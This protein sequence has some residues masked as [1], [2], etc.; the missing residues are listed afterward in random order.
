MLFLILVTLITSQILHFQAEE[1]SIIHIFPYVS[2]P[3]SFDMR[4]VT[5]FQLPLFFL[6]VW[7][8]GVMLKAQLLCT[9]EGN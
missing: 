7:S 3:R 5:L 9:P 1:F 8:Q 2:D 6:L 4:S